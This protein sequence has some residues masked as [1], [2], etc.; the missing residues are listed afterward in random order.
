MT[1]IPQTYNCYCR[2]L[3]AVCPFSTAVPAAAP[4]VSITAVTATSFT[5]S[6]QPLPPCEQNG[7]ITNYTILITMEGMSFDERTV[8]ANVTSALFTSLS[9]FTTYGVQL[10]ASTMIGRGNFSSLVTIRTNES[11]TSPHTL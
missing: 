6:W 1:N 10:A 7:D 5:V 3:P 2:L 11:G 8:I 4:V 9:P